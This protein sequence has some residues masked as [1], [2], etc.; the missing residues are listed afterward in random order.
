MENSNINCCMELSYEDSHVED[1]RIEDL[2]F[3]LEGVLGF[4]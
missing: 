4:A 3:P 2:W 1:S